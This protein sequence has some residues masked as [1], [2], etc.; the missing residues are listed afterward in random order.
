MPSA[1]AVVGTG[2]IGA[3]IG[4]ALAREDHQV[5][6]LDRAAPGVAGASFGNVGHIATELVQPLPSLKLICGFW[7]QLTCFGGPLDLPLGRIPGLV[8][9]MWRFALAAPRQSTNTRHLASLVL[10]AAA[11]LERWLAQ[12]G[13]SELLR[14]HGHYEVRFGPKAGAAILAQSR[15]MEQLG[16]STAP[17]STQQLERVRHAAGAESASGLWFDGAAHVLDP[18]EI[19]RAFVDAA[20]ARGATVKA[21]NV[22]TVRPRGDEVEVLGES[23]S[24]TVQGAVICAGVDSAP[25]LAPFGLKAP[26][27]AARGYH[28]ELP[29]HAPVLDAPILYADHNL[30]VTPM[31]GRLRASSFVEFRSPGAPKDPRKIAR[32]RSRVRELGYQCEVNGDAWVG[33]RPVLPDYLPGIGKA[34]GSARVYYAVGHQHIG[35]TM[36]TTTADLVADLVAQRPPR[37][38]VAPFDLRRFGARINR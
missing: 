31:S 6:F 29:G 30:I 26:L 18:L 7:P 17:M 21:M 1:I 12:I 35:L 16:I 13:R 27:Q 23:A 20:V 14:R 24:M 9:W 8:P 10:P 2:V 32:L 36:A 19:V 33:A 34:P 5:I 37:V 28:V 22:R 3:A 15:G 38:P 25:L 4:Y 11:N